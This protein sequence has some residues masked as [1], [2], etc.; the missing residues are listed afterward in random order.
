[1]NSKNFKVGTFNVYN[2]VLPNVVYYDNRQYSTEV[3]AKKKAWIAHQLNCMNADIVGFQEIFHVEALQQA[4]EESKLYPNAK[5][6]A[7]VRTGEGPIVALVSRFPVLRHRVYEVF[8]A[9][10]KLT[11]EGA[12]IPIHQFS[13]AVLAVDVAL[14]SELECTIFV[15]HLKSKHPIFPD[16][17]DRNDPIEKAKGQA[18]ALIQ[19]AGEAIALRVILMEFLKNRNYPVILMGDINDGGLAVTSQI[20]S[21][22]PPFRKIS[23]EQKQKNWD[24]LLYHVKDIQS[25]RSYGDYYYTHIHNGHYESLDH[26]MVSQ[27]FVAENPHHIGRVGYVSVLN[28]H[29]LDDTLSDD[30]VKLWQSDHGQVIAAIELK[31]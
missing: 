27:E 29:L 20:M 4:L 28:D 12:A 5:V 16:D 25:R 8:P 9:E 23:F 13:R 14:T 19:R 1:M 24:V 18:R 21:G 30:D 26:I 31:R 22:E 3:F 6:V 17:V 11:I 10:A 2:L 7:P 15:V